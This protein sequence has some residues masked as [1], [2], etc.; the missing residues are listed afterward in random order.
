MQEIL[1]IQQIIGISRVAQLA[2]RG[3]NKPKV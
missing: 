1:N 2:E 3:S